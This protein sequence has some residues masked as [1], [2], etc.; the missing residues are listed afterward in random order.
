MSTRYKFT[1]IEGMYFITSTVVDWI[2]LPAG[3]QVYL[4]EMFT[5][6][7]FWIVL[8]FARRNKDYRY[9]PGS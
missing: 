7:F 5:E 3:K 6:I 9:M 2:D 8:G 4:Q 1:E